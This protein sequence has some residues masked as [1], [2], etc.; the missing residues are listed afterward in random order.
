[1]I[2]SFSPLDHTLLAAGKAF[3]AEVETVV[4]LLPLLPLLFFLVLPNTV[5]LLVK[6]ELLA[7]V[8]VA[9]LAIVGLLAIGAE[10]ETEF[11]V[12]PHKPLLFFL[13]LP[14]TVAL[15]VKVELLAIVI[16]SLLA[17]G[18]EVETV[19]LVLPHKPLLFF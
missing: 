1:M 14:S 7:I 12:L 8:I 2:A 10:V 19:F 13:V 15:L 9:L 5:A 11:L 16:V 18:A 4:L 3:L 6:V 17:I